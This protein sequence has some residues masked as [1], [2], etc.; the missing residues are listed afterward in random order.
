MRAL[1]RK[2]MSCAMVAH[3][4]VSR[5]LYAH[6][7][8][9]AESDATHGAARRASDDAAHVGPGAPAISIPPTSHL[10]VGPHGVSPIASPVSSPP[11][12][13]RPS[14]PGVGVG[15]KP[16]P[17]RGGGGMAGGGQTSLSIELKSS[18]AR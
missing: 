3:V 1:L 13:P 14:S 6:M 10:R 5:A 17:S 15:A 4:T 18:G 7:D 9:R 2:K 16:S 11:V 8:T 12:G